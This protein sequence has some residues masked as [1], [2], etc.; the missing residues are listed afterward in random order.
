MMWTQVGERVE[1][2]RKD[3]RLSR[4]QFGEMIGVSGR[5]IG[6]VERGTNRLSVDSVVKICHS[7]NVTADY[8]LFGVVHPA[9]DKATSAAL[10]GISHEQIQ[11]ALDIVKRVAQLVNTEDG[12]EALIQEIVKQQINVNLR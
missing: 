6:M 12:N 10:Y 9:H 1:R 5:Y 2:M 7:M 3:R 11:I 4:M 8:L